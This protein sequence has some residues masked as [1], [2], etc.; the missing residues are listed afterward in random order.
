[1]RI[2][3]LNNISLLKW[4]TKDTR[5]VAIKGLPGYNIALAMDLNS[6][7]RTHVIDGILYD[8]SNANLAADMEYL[9]SLFRTSQVVWVDA[10]DQ[11]QALCAFGKIAKMQGP[12]IDS[13]Q[14]EYV[15]KFTI[16]FWSVLPWGTTLFNTWKQSGFKLRDIDGVGSEYMLD[17]TQ[18]HC[19]FTINSTSAPYYVSWEFVLENQNSFTNATSYQETDCDSLG[20]GT[21]SATNPVAV[22]PAVGVSAF[23]SISIDTV[24]YK[25]GTGSLKGTKSGPSASTWYAFGY[26]FGTTGVD[27]SAYDRLRMWY[28]CD[29]AGQTN[30]WMQIRDANGKYRA[31]GFALQASNTWMNL[32][33]DIAAYTQDTG[34][35]L[36]KI[37]Y[38][39]FE[40]E[41]ASNP[42]TSI[43]LWVDDIR[44]EVGYI[45]H[46]EDTSGWTTI[47]ITN[48]TIS[49]DT[50]VIKEGQSS[51]KFSG[52]GISNT[53]A[54]AWKPPTNGFDLTNYDF[55]M[56]WIRSDFGGNATGTIDVF[57]QTGNTSNEWQY[58]YPSLKAN[59][60]YRL[61]VPIRDPFATIGSPTI[62]NINRIEIT[63]S[64]TGTNAANTWIDE[65][66]VDVGNPVYLECMIPDNVS[67]YVSSSYPITL[68]TWNG[69]SYALM[70]GEGAFGDGGTSTIFYYLNGA[71]ENQIWNIY[72]GGL[73]SPNA[74][75][76]NGQKCTAASASSLPSTL[77]YTLLW[78]SNNRFGFE[79]RMP[80]A[81][82][83]SSSGNY[84]SNDLTGSQ[85]IN[86]VRIKVVVY[87]S[88]EDTTY[89]GFDPL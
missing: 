83:D 33:V 68:Y 5:D 39:A 17:P 53:Y 24:N 46:C 88:N 43:N 84:P 26:D 13:S 18:M 54:V 2:G 34:T 72:G 4:D 10:S 7:L 70:S 6:S 9:E 55:F 58:H 80:P 64:Y 63:E 67:Q 27:I 65:I 73:Y 42:P 37:R 32:L 76:Q 40:V 25:S 86:K 12:T 61:V 71:E 29:Q 19:N 15:A 38:F 41:T 22:N 20:T 28:R 56:F 79:V 69:S 52:T 1:M 11:Y 77:T 78:G 48:P 81:T 8:T 30:Y 89:V 59:L 62:S 44:V 85:A 49:N 21:A 75:G 23:D 82:S 14:G 16:E 87:Y 45:N 3:S 35:D 36:T 50:T 57:L 47:N 66:A 74:V 31:W 51:T 60:W